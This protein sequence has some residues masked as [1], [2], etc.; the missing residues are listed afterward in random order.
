MFN[1]S[2]KTVYSK[3]HCYGYAVLKTIHKIMSALPEST[4]EVNITMSS[5]IYSTFGVNTVN[6]ILNNGVAKKK[7]KN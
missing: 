5:H 3:C 2:L 6:Q 1:D 7:K 4:A